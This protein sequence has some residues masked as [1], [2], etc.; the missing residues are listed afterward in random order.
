LTQQLAIELCYAPDGSP[1]VWTAVLRAIR[2]VEPWL[3]PH[4]LERPGETEDEPWQESWWDE[5]VQVCAGEPL[6]TRNLICEAGTLRVANREYELRLTLTFESDGDPSEALVR[7]LEA[8]GN[9]R[10]PE[11][12]LAFDPSSPEDGELLFQGRRRLDRIP[13]IFY[14]DRTG[15]AAVGGFARVRAQAPGDVRVAANGLVFVTRT[16]LWS[17]KTREDLQREKALQTFLDLTKQTPLALAAHEHIA[18]HAGEPRWNIVRHWPFSDEGL[19]NQAWLGGGDGPWIVGELGT[20]ARW[21]GSVWNVVP[22][23]C[24]ADLFAVSDLG[25]ANAW[26]VGADGT[27]LHWDGRAWAPVASPTTNALAAV[28]A[29]GPD[30]AFAAGANGTILRW[31][32]HFWV[33]MRTDTDVDFHAITGAGDTMWAVGANGTIAQWNGVSWTR[34]ESPTQRALDSVHALGED[35]WAAGLE[36]TILR[37]HEGQWSVFDS[38][39]TADLRSIWVRNDRDIWVAGDDFTL[40][41][42]NGATWTALR[43]DTADEVSLLRIWPADD[44]GVWAVGTKTTIVLAIPGS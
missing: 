13:P 39:T 4:T 44:E 41:H 34:A 24:E 7:V 37:R 16:T 40:R 1:Q 6:H 31:D 28:W 27:I 2:A 5:I 20:I 35:V 21:D 8:V 19:P 10:G 38:E 15:L 11:L 26:A 17:K 42:W 43:D 30:N 33:A 22:A 14:L 29:S 36:G 23:N 9:A 25:D 18:T 3:L 32:G 12:A